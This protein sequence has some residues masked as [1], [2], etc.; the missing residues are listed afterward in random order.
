MLALEAAAL[1]V[2]NMP[3]GSSLLGVGEK[4]GNDSPLTQR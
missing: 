2:T 4:R 1:R 3:L